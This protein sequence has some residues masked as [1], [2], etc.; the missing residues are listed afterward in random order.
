MTLDPQKLRIEGVYEQKQPGNYM[1]RVKVPGGVLS[2]EQAAKAAE[3]AERFAGGG[4]HLTTRA[5]IEFHWV[6]GEAL[7]EVARMLAAVGLTT[8]GACGG[9]VRGI[10]CSAPFGEGFPAAQ[11]LIRK[12]HHHF[13]QNPHFEGL[14]K[15][16]KIGVDAGYRNSRHLIQDTGLVLA[17]TEGG[18]DRYDVWMA[19]GL[20]REPQ[21]AFLFERGVAEERI[22]PLIEAVVTVY[23]RLTPLGKRLKHLVRERGEAGFRELLETELAGK[24]LLLL[25]D[26]FAKQLTLPVKAAEGAFLEAP[27]FAGELPAAGLRGLA[28]VAADHAGGY[29]VLTCD[30]NVAFQVQYG[31]REEAEQALITAGFRG[32]PGNGSFRV[33]PGSHECRMG[34][35]PTRDVA[36]SVLEAMGSAGKG[37]SWA[38]SGCQNSCSQP[39]LAG[40]GIVV[41]RLAKEEDG[42]RSPR[43][44]LYRRS[45]ADAFGIPCRQ[46]LSLAE[47]LEAVRAIG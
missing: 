13:T 9:A 36:R 3:I 24:A 27:V 29:M 37:I 34:L 31:A 42:E 47:L 11:V 5:S 4:L 19:G 43:F 40:A 25:G 18:Q 41:S 2:T 16:F 7:P 38:I 30:Q 14:P 22:I 33:C 46:G 12:L 8:R 1:V 45:V 32:A 39:Q 20:G 17:G 26:G 23:R 35:A 28:K 6:Q 44:D 15:K 10:V 21:P